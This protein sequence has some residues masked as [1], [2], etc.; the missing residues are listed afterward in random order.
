MIVRADI[1]AVAART[2]AAL[3]ASATNQGA[4]V[5]ACRC[6]MESLM[7]DTA[8]NAALVD[9]L[10]AKPRREGVAT[11]L[12]GPTTSRRDDDDDDD[13]EARAHAIAGTADDG[14]GEASGA[15]TSHRRRKA[16]I[17]ARFR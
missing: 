6:V 10:E 13:D 17:A 4:P 16:R 1:G 5:A 11:T 9:A 3:A 14:K 2:N 15:W 12:D 8:S 7:S